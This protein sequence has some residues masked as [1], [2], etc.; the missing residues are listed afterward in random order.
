MHSLL[1][2]NYK[3][4]QFFLKFM[5]VFVFSDLKSLLKNLR[6]K[7][8]R[9]IVTPLIQEHLRDRKQIFKDYFAVEDVN[10]CGKDEEIKKEALVYCTKIEEFIKLLALLRGENF[11]EMTEKIGMDMGKGKLKLT[12]T[13]YDEDNIIPMQSASRASREDG[14]GAG[15]VYR[16]LGGRNVIVLAAV[17][18]IPEN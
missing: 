9:N 6:L 18:N 11:T 8:G 13:M 16:D 14:M 4:S 5:N 17:S 7:Y 12:L 10:F 2:H 3:I 15:N 1:N